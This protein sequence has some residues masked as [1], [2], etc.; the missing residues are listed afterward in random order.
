MCVVARVAGASNDR[1]CV[2]YR[3]AGMRL[4]APT[5]MAVCGVGG[6]VP[7]GTNLCSY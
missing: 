3:C 2:N 4:A 6:S 7:A 5:A 1:C